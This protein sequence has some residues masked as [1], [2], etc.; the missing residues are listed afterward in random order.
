MKRVHIPCLSDVSIKDLGT[1]EY[2]ARKKCIYKWQTDVT[3][4]SVRFA[5]VLRVNSSAR[6]VASADIPDVSDMLSMV[7]LCDID[8]A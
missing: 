7:K 5:F 1:Y 3:T 2:E 6:S 4:S 8:S